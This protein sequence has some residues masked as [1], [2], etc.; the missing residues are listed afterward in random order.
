MAITLH[1]SHSNICTFK[2]SGLH[3]NYTRYP[4]E[5]PLIEGTITGL[6][7]ADI[8]KDQNFAMGKLRYSTDT[9]DMQS[10]LVSGFQSD[11]SFPTCLAAKVTP[12]RAN[13]LSTVQT[14]CFSPHAALE[15]GN[16]YI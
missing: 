7:S 10:P 14:A 15:S 8:S 1:H 5:E 2:Y 6:S 12:K 13:M 9:Y 16:L 4:T 11:V 3:S